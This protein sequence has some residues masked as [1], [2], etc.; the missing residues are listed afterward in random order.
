M[1][2]RYLPSFWNSLPKPAFVLA[3]MA[4]VTDPA[5]RRIL[6]K[7]GKPDVTW[8]EFVSADGLFMGG[9]AGYAALVRDLEYTEAERPIVAQFFTSRPEN[10]EKAARLARTLGYDG[11][12]I[13]MG[14]PDKSIEGQGCGAAMIKDPAKA[15]E[16]IRAAKR[17]AEFDEDGA[18]AAKPIPV[19]VKTRLGFNT[20]ILEEWLPV[21]LAERPAAITLHARTRKEMSK[22]PAH[23]DRIKDAVMLRDAW[24]EANE[25]PADERTPIF[26]NGD[27]VD[28]ADARRKAAETGC[29]GVMIGRACF[30]NPWIFARESGFSPLF[31]SGLVKDADGKADYGEVGSLD[32]AAIKDR[33][34]VMVEHAT[35]FA[36][37]LPHKSFS[38]MK[39]HFK[40]YVS[41]W[42]GAKE[43]R[44]KLMAAK[45]AV[46]VK[47]VAE[48][49]CASL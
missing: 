29:D 30:G 44:M 19:S 13:N 20:D 22:V 41:G 5:F 36:E 33:L 8:T 15:I 25:V 31:E 24:S 37:I 18:P 39:K 43:L 34:A 40:A 35:L 6:A 48:E 47:A 42:P 17:G 21:L 10:M 23:W 3:P 26:G 11:V 14:C 9:G 32:V 16:V 46:E 27:V 28:K 7:Y 1:T 12:D 45:D 2:S 4:D 38:I 49:Y